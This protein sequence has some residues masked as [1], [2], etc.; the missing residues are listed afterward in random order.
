MGS[1]Y[2]RADSAFYWVAFEDAQGKRRLKSS[3]SA[4]EGVANR[5]LASIERKVR[6]EKESGIPVAQG[7]ITVAAYAKKWLKEREERGISNVQDDTSRLAH[8]LPTLGSM[9]LSSVRHRHIVTAIREVEKKGE[10]A[11][12]SILNAYGALRLMFGD[13]VTE[14]LIETSPATLKRHRGE[15]PKRRDKNPEW[16]ALAIF[17]REEVEILISDER[18]P[19]R[20]RVLYAV[21]FL[22]GVRINEVTPRRWRDYDAVAVPLG[23]LTVSTA[24]ARKHRRVKAPKTGNARLVPVHPTLARVLAEWKMRGW[25]ETYGRDPKADDLIV[26]SAHGSTLSSNKELDNLKAALAML[27]LRPRRQHDSRRTFITLAQVDGGRREILETVTHDPKGDITSLYTTFPWP[28]RCAEVAKLNIHLREGKVLKLAAS[29]EAPRT[30]PLLVATQPQPAPKASGMSATE[31]RGSTDDSATV[32]LRSAEPGAMTKETASRGRALYTEERRQD[33]PHRAVNARIHSESSGA[34][35]ELRQVAPIDRSN[36]AALRRHLGRAEDLLQECEQNVAATAPLLAARLRAFLAAR[37]PPRPI[38]S[39]SIE[40]LRKKAK[41]GR[42]IYCGDRLPILLRPSG[43]KRETCKTAAC[44]RERQR[45]W[46]NDSRA[47]KR[48]RG[49]P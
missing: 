21:L 42:C 33:A 16:R 45:V 49:E 15:L 39:P 32:L 4:D 34:G 12:R 31:L 28:T 44:V 5:M 27:G 35:A 9:V 19:L 8:V 48:G 24:Y 2:K 23:R 46:R 1:V 18:I 10:L 3:K 30:A 7:P 11:P 25:R 29:A 14:E 6:A 38:T 13:A 36:V 41:P 40:A 20:Q 17:E 26:P 47:A 43:K 37:P 22:T